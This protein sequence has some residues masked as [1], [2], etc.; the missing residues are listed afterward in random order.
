MYGWGGIAIASVVY[1]L[2]LWAYL[3][4]N[5]AALSTI[6]EASPAAVPS[7]LARASDLVAPGTFVLDAAA[8]GSVVPLVFAAGAA[9]LAIGFIAVVASFGR[10]AAYLYAV[11]GIAPVAALAIGPILAAPDGAVLVLTVVIPVVTVGLFLVDAGRE[12]L[13][14]P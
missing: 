4:A 8:A 14:D 1:L 5:A 2:G 10:G 7:V 3:G 6:S 11:G 13:G 12:L 9:G